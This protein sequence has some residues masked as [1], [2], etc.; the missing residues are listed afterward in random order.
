[1]SNVA[2][3]AQ[4]EIERLKADGIE[5]TLEEIVWLNDLGRKVESPAGRVDYALAGFPIRCGN[6]V[7]WPFSI[8]SGNWFD[9]VCKMFKTEAMQLYCL[10]FAFANARNPDV[11]WETLNDYHGVRDTVNSW[12]LH[13]GCTAAELKAAISRVL[14]QMDYPHPIKAKAR[15]DEPKPTS[16]IAD[17]V[18]GTGLSAEYWQNKP[19]SFAEQCMY[20]VMAQGDHGIDNKGYKDALYKDACYDF[21]AASDA[22]RKA[23]AHG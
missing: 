7:L 13:T 5:C 10:G 22:I 17:L 6:L 20:A 1:M 2:E 23:H 3:I 14:P 9:A 18:A 11:Q 16:F 12:A 8:A 4:A 19:W 15:N 21:F